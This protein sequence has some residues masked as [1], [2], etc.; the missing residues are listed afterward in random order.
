MD[1]EQN[2]NLDCEN[3]RTSKQKY[4]DRVKENYNFTGM[5][6]RFC[7]WLRKLEEKKNKK[8]EVEK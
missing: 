1:E 7:E 4:F 3:E 5:L 6:Y 2:K 8:R